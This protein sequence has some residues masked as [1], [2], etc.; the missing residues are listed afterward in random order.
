MSRLSIN[1]K[2]GERI[3]QATPISP[4]I[5]AVISGVDVSQPISDVA[6][7]FIETALLQYQVIFFRNQPI[8]PAQHAAFTQCFGGLHIHPVYPNVPEQPEILVLD[9]AK[10]NLKDN[11]LWHTDVTFLQQP[12]L[13]AVLSAKKVP[14]IGGDTLWSSGTAAYEALSDSF[15]ELLTGLTATHDIAKSFPIERFGGTPVQRE[16]LENAKQQ[17]PPVSHPVIRTHPVTGKQAIFVNEGFTTHINELEPKESDVVLN[18]LFQ[19]IQ[20]PDFVVRW[21]WQTNDIA[22]WDNRVTFH[23]A[24]DDYQPNHRI[25]QRATI[26]GDTPFYQQ[27]LPID[28]QYVS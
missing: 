19:H 17:H 13:G 23:Y 4:A 11:A 6:K 27:T 25:M 9:S 18:F 24:I 1:M 15:K 8:S 7:Q 16:Q 3:F 12:A 21:Q 26:L 28:E 20:K 22:F 5:G 10:Q 2:D 14:E